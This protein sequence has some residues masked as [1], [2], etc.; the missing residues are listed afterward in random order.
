MA[1][2]DDLAED[3]D[4]SGVDELKVVEKDGVLYLV[5]MNDFPE[6]EEHEAS[7]EVDNEENS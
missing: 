6:Q 4:D 3:F 1:D 7:E 2:H 5:D